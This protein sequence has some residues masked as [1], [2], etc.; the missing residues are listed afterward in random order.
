MKKRFLLITLLAAAL[1]PLLGTRAQAA[2]PPPPETVI[3]DHSESLSDYAAAVVKL[4][5]LAQENDISAAGLPEDT[6]PGRLTAVLCRS[7]DPAADYSSL[8]PAYVIYGPEGCD[9]LY[10]YGEDAAD[11]AVQ[12]LS[13]MP[14]MRYAE[15]EAEV[16]ACEYAPKSAGAV[17]ASFPEY[18]TYAAPNV[19]GEITVAVVDSGISLHPDLVSRIRTS[20]WDYIDGDDDATN[21]QFGHG[22]NVGGI[23]A[24]CTPNLPVYL[25]P[26]RVLNAYGKGSS[27]NTAIA[28]REAMEAGADIINLSLCS[29]G[30]LSVI[31]DAVTDAVAA[32]ITVCAAAGN[33]GQDT[34]GYTPA[35]LEL[36][37]LIVAG[38]VNSDGSL[39]SYSNYGRSVDVYACGSS[40]RC[41]S[42][43]GGYTYATGTSMSAPHVSAAAATQ[44]LLH[45]GLSPQQIETRMV[46]A[47]QSISDLPNLDLSLMI[48]RDFGFRL[49]DLQ[50]NLTDSL[51]LPVAAL[52]ASCMES[53]EYTVENP[54]VLEVRD[55]G[56]TPVGPGTTVVEAAC[57]GLAPM[58]FT[59]TVTDEPACSLL[60]P[61]GL[62]RLDAAAFE[63][64][65]S[66]RRVTLPAGL[67]ELSSDTFSGCPKLQFVQLPESALALQDISFGNAVLLCPAESPCAE[68]LP[69]SDLQYLLCP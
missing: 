60:L 57:L 23:I 25:H 2:D 7:D 31:D 46:A 62:L 30:I 42:R 38:S 1:F 8:A 32:G 18:L 3:L 40:I 13:A 49:S 10:F 17:Q 4:Q 29:T 63:G 52:P 48:P 14:G 55:G 41:C 47:T 22:T 53:M 35:H 24:D 5:Q 69:G 39:A 61:E 26:I 58:R 15:R 6:P 67:Q 36:S 20:G 51:P 66:L 33:A 28:I 16:Y 34:S 65:T 59:V 44:L 54:E 64:C 50:L 12:I 21:D 11:R 9:T 56:L 27:N 43:D 45:P 68:L 37:G 19:D